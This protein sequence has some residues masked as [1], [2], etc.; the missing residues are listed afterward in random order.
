MMIYDCPKIA[1]SQH[2]LSDKHVQ[3]STSDHNSICPSVRLCGYIV[4]SLSELL[5][6]MLCEVEPRE[7]RGG[8]DRLCRELDFPGV[9]CPLLTT[10]EMDGD[11][12]ARGDSDGV[13]E[14]VMA[15][16]VKLDS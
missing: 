12:V 3:T 10:G 13:R 2:C 15:A 16:D 11:R 9:V 14:G 5:E 1:T 6:E 8:L 7:L 4:N